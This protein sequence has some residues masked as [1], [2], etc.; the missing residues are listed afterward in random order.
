MWHS[1]QASVVNGGGS[2]GG[3]AK[4]NSVPRSVRRTDQQPGTGSQKYSASV[5]PSSFGR[6]FVQ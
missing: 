2:G 6:Q 3:N 4:S 1:R 5:S